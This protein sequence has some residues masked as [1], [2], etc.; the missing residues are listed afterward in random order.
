FVDSQHTRFEARDD[1]L[2]GAE[3]FSSH[4]F[5]LETQLFEIRNR[6]LSMERGGGE[7]PHGR[8]FE[9]SRDRFAYRPRAGLAIQTHKYG[10]K[11]AHVLGRQQVDRGRVVEQAPA[12]EL[13]YLRVCKAAERRAQNAHER[14]PVV[15]VVDGAEQIDGVDNLLD[16][17]KM[18]FALHDIAQSTASKRLDVI[19]DIGELAEQKRHVAGADETRLPAV[20]DLCFAQY[21]LVEPAGEILCL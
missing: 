2:E 5:G 11:L 4:D 15:R 12:A 1:A 7:Q 3:R 21:F 20:H 10:V 6:L 8:A 16:G 17:V 13:V 14:K 9:D 19:M 18:S